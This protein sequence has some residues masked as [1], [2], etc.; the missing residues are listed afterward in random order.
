MSALPELSYLSPVEYLRV[1][2]H[3]ETKSD[4]LNGIVVAMAGATYR[5]NIIAGNVFRRI[6]NA[7]EK[8]PCIG[9]NSDM[10]VRIE[11]A[12]V[13][14]YPDVSA[15]CGPID[16]YDGEEDI[17]TNPQ[18]I[19]EV[20]SPSTERTDKNEKFAEYRLIDSFK[21]YLIIEQKMIKAILHRKGEDNIW[22]SESYTDQDDKIE[23]ESI[24][25]SLTLREI[26]EKIEFED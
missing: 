9:F 3:A 14:R 25:V 6:G 18:F 22:T 15:L 24:H 20:L 21:E 16:F 7:F 26:Y 10:K 1:E 12:N 8:R 11:K 5:H 2:R 17:Y 23:L 4:Y 13:F 19:C